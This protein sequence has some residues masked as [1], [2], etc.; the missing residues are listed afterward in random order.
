MTPELR[1]LLIDCDSDLSAYGHGRPLSREDAIALSARCRRAYVSAPLAPAVEPERCGKELGEGFVCV[2]WK[3][4]EV[5]CCGQRPSAVEPEPSYTAGP[6]TDP[7]FYRVPALPLASTP[8]ETVVDARSNLREFLGV[9]A[10]GEDALIDALIAAVR[11]ESSPAPGAP[12]AAF[13]GQETQPANVKVGHAPVALPP[14]VEALLKEADDFT[15]YGPAIP[16][17]REGEADDLIDTLTAALRAEATARQ[18]NRTI[19][20]DADKAMVEA[21]TLLAHTRTHGHGDIEDRL[22]VFYA[23]R[24]SVRHSGIAYCLNGVLALIA[25]RQQAEQEIKRLTKELAIASDIKAL[26]DSEDAILRNYD[27]EVMRFK[28]RAEQAEAERDALLLAQREGR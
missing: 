27:A 12:E 5:A 15:E 24:D 10:R 23:V 11:A 13:F 21:E 2:L 17:I 26:A 7:A 3:G 16:S 20:P 14:E 1:Q 25:A 9:A 4:H 19:E 28:A 6:I 18:Q 22:C 8:P